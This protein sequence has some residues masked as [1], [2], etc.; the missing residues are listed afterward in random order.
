[1]VTDLLLDLDP[2]EPK[3]Q[4]WRTYN[5]Q[6]QFQW[7]IKTCSLTY[8][9]H[10][11]LDIGC[12]CSIELAHWF[13]AHCHRA[14]MEAGFSCSSNWKLCHRSG[15]DI[16][17]THWLTTSHTIHSKSHRY[18]LVV[19][20]ADNSP[21]SKQEAHTASTSHMLLLFSGLSSPSFGMESALILERNV[22]VRLPSIIHSVHSDMYQNQ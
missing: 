9:S 16:Q 19:H 13:L 2:V 14:L 8:L 18:R 10:Y 5:C 21:R 12:F 7:L 17:W 6:H 4:T 3:F 15:R 20:R 11:I 22:F 1:M